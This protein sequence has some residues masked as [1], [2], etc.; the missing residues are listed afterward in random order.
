[1]FDDFDQPPP[2]TF[3]IIFYPDENRQDEDFLR[4]VY[5]P[6]MCLLSVLSFFLNF[7]FFFSPFPFKPPP[8]L[9][10]HF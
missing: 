9:Q 10:P 6:K 8:P 2:P 7:K 5:N 3:E 4:K 1:M